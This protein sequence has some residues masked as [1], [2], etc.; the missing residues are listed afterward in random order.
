MGLRSA[1]GLL[2]DVYVM[3]TLGSLGFKTWVGAKDLHL[4]PLHPGDDASFSNDDLFV[5]VQQV[6]CT[7][8][9]Y[10][11]FGNIDSEMS[12]VVFVDQDQEIVGLVSF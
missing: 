12:V 6:K 7:T 8:V 10:L 4:M 5:A 2:S 3:A 11:Q 9:Q 1:G